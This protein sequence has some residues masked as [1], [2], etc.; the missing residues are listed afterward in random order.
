[1]DVG[2]EQTG[3]DVKK[4]KNKSDKENQINELEEEPYE[5]SDN[6]KLVAEK[7]KRNEDKLKEL[8]LYKPKE[9][10]KQKKKEKRS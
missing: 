7:R 10:S 3:T 6:E 4:K 5:P 9:V 2:K 8:G 1:L